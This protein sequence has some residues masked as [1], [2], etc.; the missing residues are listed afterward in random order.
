MQAYNSF[1]N[2]IVV[3]LFSLY[4]GNPSLCGRP[5]PCHTGECA[6]NKTINKHVCVCPSG[7]VGNKCQT[8]EKK[9]S[10]KV[11]QLEQATL[12]HLIGN[13]F[14]HSYSPSSCSFFSDNRPK[15]NEDCIFME[16]KKTIFQCET[17]HLVVTQVLLSNHSSWNKKTL[18]FFSFS[19]CIFCILSLLRY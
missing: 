18:Q 2:T 16:K 11:F 1:S 12:N 6:Y 15:K 14:S 8:G 5:S 4:S 17:S 3:S 9:S 10:A 19:I 13:C 7:V